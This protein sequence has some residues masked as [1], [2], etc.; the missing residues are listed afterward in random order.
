[1]NKINKLFN[2]FLVLVTLFGCGESVNSS[3]TSSLEDSFLEYVEPGLVEYN[4]YLDHANTYDGEYFEY[5]DSMWYINDLDKVSLPDPHVYEEDGTYYIVGTS[6]RSGCKV[7]D[8]YYTTDFVNYESA[9]GIFNPIP[10]KGWE[11]SNPLIYAPEM[12]CF[13]GVYYLYYSAVNKNGVRENSVVQADNPLGPYEPIVNDKVDGLNNPLFKDNTTVLDSTIFVDDDG[14]MYMYYSAVRGGQYIAGIKLNSPYEADYSTRKDLVIAGEISTED[15]TQALTWEA[16][17]GGPIV[18][19]PYMIKSP[20]GEY[21]L[22]YSVNGCWQK[23]YNVCYAVSDSPLGN[24]VKPYE[25][26]KSWTNLLLGYPG[27]DDTESTLFNQWSG[28]ASGTGHHCFFNI[29]D[30]IMIGYHA[31]Q[32]RNYNSLSGGFVKRYF[33]MDALYFNEDGVPYCNGPTYSLQPLPEELSGYRNIA[34]NASVRVENVNN[35]RAIND[36]YIV[37]CYNLETPDKEVNLKSGYSYIELTFDKDYTIGGLAVYNS[38]YFD[39]T[40]E[41]IKYI[42]L[43]NGNAFVYPEICYNHYNIDTEFVFPNSALTF[44]FYKQIKTNKI[45]ICFEL[46]KDC[47]INEIVVLGK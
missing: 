46:E 23:C 19:A 17:R 37:D 33:A 28:F 25:E 36:N 13:D 12:Y 16:Y 7:V 26:G 24:F 32:N 47:N 20:N 2:Y 29:G 31:H 39:K 38:A 34:L 11:N 30:Q 14:S 5:D 15:H 18:E 4:H 44:E 22:T 8:C 45:V 9:Y 6:D 1:M 41:E 27:D 40:V 21:Y 35:A 10:F 43:M 42:N 3:V